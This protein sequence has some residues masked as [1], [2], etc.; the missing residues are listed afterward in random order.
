MLASVLGVALHGSLSVK[1]TIGDAVVRLRGGATVEKL[2]YN[3]L[4]TM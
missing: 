2:P 4:G 3:V 1:S